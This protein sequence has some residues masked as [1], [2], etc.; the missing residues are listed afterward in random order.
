[1]AQNLATFEIPAGL[2]GLNRS[3]NIEQIGRDD[4]TWTETITAETLTWQKEG[5][6]IAY[7]A[8][9]LGVP[10]QA[11]WDFFSSAF[12]QE[13]VAY[14]ADGRLVTL[15]QG[16]GIAKTLASGLAQNRFGWFVE[17]WMDTATKALFFFDGVDVP[18]VYTGG[19]T[20]VPARKPNVDWSGI[21]QPAH[22][23]LHNFRLIALNVPG[24][25]HQAYLSSPQSHDHFSADSNDS[26]LLNIYPGE[27][28]FF[29][30]GTSF[31]KKAYF[32]KYPRGLYALDDSDTNIINWDGPRLTT[33]IGTAG[34]GCHCQVED[35]V[36]LLNSDGYFNAL[37]SVRT[38]D[39]ESVP[40]IF[41]IQVSD[42]IRN[43]I[44]LNRLDLVRSVYYAR[45]KHLI[46]A[47]PG[48][49]ST[50]NNRKLTIDF[51]S[52][53]RVRLFW[54]TRDEPIALAL[55]RNGQTEEP[56]IGGSD[57]TLWRLDQIARNKGGAAYTGQYEC[58][59]LPIIDGTRFAD[60]VELEVEM[61]PT[62][63]WDLT[64]EVHRDGTLSQTFDLSMQTPGGAVGSFTLDGDVLAGQTI[65]NVRQRLVGDCQY[66][67]LLARNTNADENF[68]IMKHNIRYK[69]GR[70]P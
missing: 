49:G 17:G 19:A 33:A 4:L 64:M 1:M 54:S 3:Q 24:K 63:N 29:S 62:G 11:A 65:A 35:D 22:G 68:S 43:N 66:I 23:F 31:R 15:T 67:K 38:L 53:G 39:Q 41:P 9:P 52:P 70:H 40:P 30:G 36:I 59:S 45:K 37:S 44:N 28:Q 12:V 27:G 57:G 21:N 8:S 46:Y 13:Q 2:G 26:R 58:P 34:P 20:A 47:M 7:N 5:G 14:L 48:T 6:A 55:R 32:F 61:R 42:F 18:L 56:V 60:L 10:I 25:G 50:V 16:G 69:P 51:N